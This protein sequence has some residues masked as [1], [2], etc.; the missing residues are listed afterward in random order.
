MLGAVTSLAS[1]FRRLSK[2]RMWI[3]RD[4][5]DLDESETLNQSWRAEGIGLAEKEQGHCK[6]KK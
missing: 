6:T 3:Q 1:A 2:C 5:D 4:V